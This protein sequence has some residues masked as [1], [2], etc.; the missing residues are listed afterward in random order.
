MDAR[1]KN[2]KP[3]YN[4]PAGRKMANAEAIGKNTGAIQRV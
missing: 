1:P 2:W 4:R 3:G